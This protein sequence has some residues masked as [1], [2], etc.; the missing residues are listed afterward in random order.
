MSGISVRTLHY[1]D[2][3]GLLKPS[4]RS[5]SGYR[6]YGEEEWLRL[7]QILFF[8][9]LDVPLKD[10]GEILDGPGFN[11]ILSLENHKGALESRKER[12]ETLI[13]T[14]NFTIEKLKEGNKMTDPKKLYEGLPKEMGT[15]YRDEAISDY[16]KKAV[17]RSEESLMKMGKEGFENLKAE[18]Q[19]VW[20]ELFELREASAKSEMVQ[21]L[22]ASHYEII[23]KFWGSSTS[24]D[25]QAEAFAALGDLYVQDERF[26]RVDGVAYPEFGKFMQEAMRHFVNTNFK[27]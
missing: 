9:E 1:Y 5:E 6:I 21:E 14:L 22:I 25:P 27:D 4:Q 11:R 12:L 17:D 8:R 2:Q 13:H 24:P 16:G 7:Q 26:T 15:T 18:Q 3:I 19:R 23:R 10:I 20:N